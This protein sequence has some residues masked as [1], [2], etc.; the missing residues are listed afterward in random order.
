MTKRDLEAYI[1]GPYGTPATEIFES[2][3]AVL[4]AA[5]IGLDTFKFNLDINDDSRCAYVKI[6]VRTIFS[7]LPC[8]YFQTAE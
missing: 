1:D 8:R 4:I 2:E 5:G 6:E 3:H 7:L